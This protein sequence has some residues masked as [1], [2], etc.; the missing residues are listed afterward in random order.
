MPDRGALRG[1]T[2][3]V[4]LDLDDFGAAGELFE[5]VRLR[6]VTMDQLEVSGLLER[7]IAVRSFVAGSPMVR[8]LPVAAR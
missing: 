4:A 7:F 5:F 2:C 1:R 8:D 3:C 6:D